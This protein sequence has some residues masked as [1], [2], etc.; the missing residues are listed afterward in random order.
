MPE[1]KL[2]GLSGPDDVNDAQPQPEHS[3]LATG[4]GKLGNLKARQRRN[5]RKSGFVSPGGDEGT[6]DPA[7]VSL[8]SS[9]PTT[10]IPKTQRESLSSESP[11]LTSRSDVT[12]PRSEVKVESKRETEER[13][14]RT[15]GQRVQRRIQS[16]PGL[17]S[18]P[19]PTS[20]AALDLWKSCARCAER[21]FERTRS[22]CS[23]TL[24]AI[25]QSHIDKLTRPD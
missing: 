5:K 9:H 1:V 16:L 3:T 23:R 14:Q 2:C 12:S 7:R 21:E 10:P 8:S 18:H 11:H 25:A 20:K 6:E 22:I 15:A 19:D 13:H 24:L 4:N 17:P